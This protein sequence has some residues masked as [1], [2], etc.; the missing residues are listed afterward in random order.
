ME[1]IEQAAKLAGADEFIREMS[2]GYNTSVGERRYE[3]VR[4][5]EAAY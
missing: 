2:D 1:E 4:W 5:S 3:A